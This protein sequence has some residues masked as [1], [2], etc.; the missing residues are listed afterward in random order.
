MLA[1]SCRRSTDWEMIEIRSRN[2]PKRACEQQRSCDTGTRNRAAS[3]PKRGA[4]AIRNVSSQPEF[5]QTT[6]E[7]GGNRHHPNFHRKTRR[8]SLSRIQLRADRRYILGSGNG[9]VTGNGEKE[10]SNRSWKKDRK[11]LLPFLS[12]PLL[13][14]CGEPATARIHPTP[15]Q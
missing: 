15:V 6:T 7:F 11:A 8:R 9:F 13:C 12:L 4:S 2:S 5:G 1:C 14:C 3:S 10:E